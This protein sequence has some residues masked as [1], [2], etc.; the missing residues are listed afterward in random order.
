MS[1]IHLFN[2]LAC[3][4]GENALTEALAIVLQVSRQ[5]NQQ[6]LSHLG[7]GQD[8]VCIETQQAD[9]QDGGKPDLQL[10]CEKHF[11]LFE[12]KE[13]AVLSL[14]QWNRYKVIL[15]NKKF[16]G[17]KR[18]YGVVAPWTRIEDAITNTEPPDRIVQWLTIYQVAHKSKELEK[19][20]A[21]RFLLNEF[22]QFLEDRG[23]KPFERFVPEDIQLIKSLHQINVKLAS[24]FLEVFHEVSRAVGHL[25]EIKSRG[26]EMSGYKGY[27]EL[28]P[29]IYM[30]FKWR[31][32]D[33]SSWV[34]MEC[35]RVEPAFTLWVWSDEMWKKST[36]S[37][38]LESLQ[39]VLAKIGFHWDNSDGYFIR[40]KTVLRG[41]D[42][43]ASVA[44]ETAG[45]LRNILTSKKN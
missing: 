32:F 36:P 11:L 24:F 15:K 17:D 6:F 31:S 25:S 22:M 26:Y 2:R 7:I 13:D 43:V 8:A 1:T 3:T 45:H 20:E 35:G 40:L 12:I 28:Y 10:T 34:G 27:D 33:I 38:D 19:S 5:F 39:Q 4:S 30:S 42:D 44:N 18:L 21:N 37:K 14:E 9:D 29:G 16:D 41:L 23:M